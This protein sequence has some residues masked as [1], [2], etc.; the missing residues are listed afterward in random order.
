MVT[1]HQPSR[2]L[3][4]RGMLVDVVVDGSRTGGAYTVLDVR[5]V[6][7]AGAQSH[8]HELEDQTLL[9]LEGELEVLLDEERSL[10]G[11]GHCVRLPRGVPHAYDARGAA[12]RF[13][14]LCL[15]AGFE[16]YVRTTGTAAAA[17]AAPGDAPPPGDLDPDDVA[18]LRALAGVRDL[19]TSA[20]G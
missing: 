18:A 20:V 2:T 17:G 10:V 3:W 19:G 12:V 16:R 8:L 4:H 15:P 1:P 9:V 11:A 6:H 14:C 13:L 7:G 5:L